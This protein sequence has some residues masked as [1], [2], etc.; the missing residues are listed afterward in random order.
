MARS[1]FGLIHGDQE[2]ESADTKAS[3]KSSY[4][5]LVPFVSG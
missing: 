4:H 5:D 1:S 2:G 3:N